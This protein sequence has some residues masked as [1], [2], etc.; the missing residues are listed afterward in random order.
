MRANSL[1]CLTPTLPACRGLEKVEVVATVGIKKTIGAMNGVDI[2]IIGSTISGSDNP[3]EASK[4]LNEL[5][6]NQV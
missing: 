1:K 4:R 5:I 3:G 2:A 6:N